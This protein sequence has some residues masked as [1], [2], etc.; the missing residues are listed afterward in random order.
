LDC[1]QT[2]IRDSTG[3]ITLHAPQW[4]RQVKNFYIKEWP[5]N[6]ASLITEGGLVVWFSSSVEEAKEAAVHG[7]ETMVAGKTLTPGK[8]PG[9]NSVA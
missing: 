6:T 7:K 2:V 1:H 5:D 4:R 9:I 8:G 3:G